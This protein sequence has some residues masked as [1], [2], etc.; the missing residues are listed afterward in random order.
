MK[1]APL[2]S[3]EI[4]SLF[5]TAIFGQG[6]LSFAPASPI[7]EFLISENLKLHKRNRV[8]TEKNA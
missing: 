7:W 8:V 2:K 3:G 4:T 6:V 1:N 5:L